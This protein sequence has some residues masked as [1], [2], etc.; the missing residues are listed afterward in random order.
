MHFLRDKPWLW[1]I[2]TWTEIAIRPLKYLYAGDEQAQWCGGGSGAGGVCL[3]SVTRSD[4]RKFGI[5]FCLENL[6]AV[7]S[8]KPNLWK[9]VETSARG[10]ANTNLLSLTER[11]ALCTRSLQWKHLYNR[12]PPLSSSFQS[13]VWAQSAMKTKVLTMSFQDFWSLFPLIL[14]TMKL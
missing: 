1:E 6:S 13:G 7:E 2:W 11:V 9:R 8:P 3:V 14:I 10:W 5:F 12:A 4:H